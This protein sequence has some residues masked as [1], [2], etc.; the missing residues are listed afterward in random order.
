MGLF[1]GL[2]VQI[3][4]QACGFEANQRIR[5]MKL[6]V[7]AASEASAPGAAL[8]LPDAAMPAMAPETG[9]EVKYRSIPLQRLLTLHH[10][11]SL[12]V[13]ASRLL[14]SKRDRRPY[15]PRQPLPY[16]HRRLRRSR[17][18]LS[19]MAA[20]VSIMERR[21]HSASGIPWRYSDCHILKARRLQPLFP[22]PCQTLRVFKP[23]APRLP[24]QGINLLFRS[25]SVFR[26]LSLIPGLAQ[27]PRHIGA[28]SLLSRSRPGYARPRRSRI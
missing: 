3:K 12:A 10:P 26:A 25:E 11:Y 6:E 2:S 14:G 22:L 19:G 4:I 5:A 16:R 8:A 17:S 21:L 13:S 20:N 27:P 28:C 18:R 15:R 9:R 23:N 24:K 1:A 7:A